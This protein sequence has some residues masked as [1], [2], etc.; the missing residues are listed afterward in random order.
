[1]RSRGMT[2]KDQLEVVGLVIIV[3]TAILAVIFGF[4]SI[5]IFCQ[6]YLELNIVEF[7]IIIFVILIG[8]AS[9]SI[10]EKERKE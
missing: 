5:V 7:S 1:M 8:T 6:Y 9:I 4:F 10:I 2:N 3:V